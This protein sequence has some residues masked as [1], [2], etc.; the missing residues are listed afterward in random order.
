MVIAFSSLSLSGLSMNLTV[1]SFPLS[2]AFCRIPGVPGV[3]GVAGL[4]GLAF[5]LPF[6]GRPFRLGSTPFVAVPAYPDG[7]ARLPSSL[8]SMYSVYRGMRL[9]LSSSFSGIRISR[10]ASIGNCGPT[11]VELR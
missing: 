5:N 10:K 2:P 6:G 3:I 8:G 7:S 1:P 9:M 11:L 4:V